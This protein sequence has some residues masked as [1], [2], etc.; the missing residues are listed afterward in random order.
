MRRSSMGTVSQKASSAA[1]RSSASGVPGRITRPVA[2]ARRR[3]RSVVLTGNNCSRTPDAS[4]HAALDRASGLGGQ[5]DLLVEPDP[6]GTTRRR[7]DD[8]REALHAVDEDPE[9]NAG[10]TPI[11]ALV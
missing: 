6:V 11:L 10:G 7:V 5:I 3:S 1:S 8:A 9:A 2:M 4:R